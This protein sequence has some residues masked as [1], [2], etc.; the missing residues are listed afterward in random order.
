MTPTTIKLVYDGRSYF[1][2]PAERKEFQR[3][4]VAHYLPVMSAK[5]A[6]FVSWWT[7][8]FAWGRGEQPCVFCGLAECGCDAIRQ[9]EKDEER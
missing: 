4:V 8:F 3:F 2:T 9:E 1:R 5:A 6:G 7:V